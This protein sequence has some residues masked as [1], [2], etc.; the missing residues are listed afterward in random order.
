MQ[1]S[2]GGS[3]I[4]Y[5]K[6]DINQA[7]I[8]AVVNTL[9]SD[10]LTQGPVVPEFEK[11]VAEVVQAKHVV[12]V[13]SATSAL[14]LAC[15]ALNLGP[16]DFLWTSPITFVAS[17]NCALYCNAQ[18]DFVDINPDTGLI[19]I[20]QLSLKLE[21]AEATGSLPKV[22]VPVHLAGT[23]CDM[24]AIKKLSIRYGFHIIEDA[25]HAI[26]GSYK[27]IPVGSCQYSDIAIFSFHP[28]KI[29]TSGEGGIATTNNT[30]LCERMKLLR[31]HGI[32]KD[33]SKFI[34]AGAEPWKYEQQLLGYNYRMTDIH[35]ALGLSQLQRL[36]SIV[37]ERNRQRL[38]YFQLLEKS[39]VT[40]LTIPDNVL[41]SVH[42]AILRLHN[43]DPSFHGQVF[44]KLRELGIGVQLH[45]SP[46]HLQP[47]FQEFGFR[48]GDFVCA[49]S[50]ATNSFSIPLFPGLTDLQIQ[51]IA[52]MIDQVVSC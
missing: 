34:T 33:S 24:Q 30:L 19:D 41:S 14:H 35:A 45:Y 23:S 44:N 15:L 1:Y 6:Q 22:V 4:P 8:D 46:V 17:A 10:Y 7:D 38:L 27:D 31:S 39:P 51:Y 42:L 28:V 50:Y 36:D 3:F 52:E 32:V 9:R 40:F 37:A 49:E 18:V 48:T 21:V 25:S 20:S 2:P 47:F 5:G 12:A 16:G 11:A 43:L 29:I 13:N 26:G